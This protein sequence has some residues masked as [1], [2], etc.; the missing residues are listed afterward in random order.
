MEDQVHELRRKLRWLSI[1]PQALRGTVHL[2]EALP[3]D[4]NVSKYL[5]PEIIQSPF[6][7]MPAPGDKTTFL[8]LDKNNFLAL[9]WMIA[10]SGKLK[11]KGLGDVAYKEALAAGN[12]NA[13]GELQN[14]NFT[15][16]GETSGY[17]LAEAT[18]IFKDFFREKR[19][20]KLIVGITNKMPEELSQKS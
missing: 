10:E 5:V 3:A 4:E 19:L 18:R 20:E 1:Y 13:D 11:D 9:S 7:I 8:L 2:T 6:N 12:G 15:S 16:D 14:L 17:L